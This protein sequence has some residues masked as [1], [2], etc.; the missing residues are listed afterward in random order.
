M[1]SQLLLQLALENRAS[2]SGASTEA[3]EGDEDEHA[4]CE[5]NLFLAGGGL[6]RERHARL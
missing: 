2:G 6:N 1:S 4:G 3:K 5:R